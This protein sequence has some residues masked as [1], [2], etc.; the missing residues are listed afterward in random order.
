[1]TEKLS[2]NYWNNRYVDNATGW[3]I[4]FISTPLKEYI[5]QL[6]DKNIS[7][8][9]PGCGN[10]H[11][12]KYLLTKGFT[13]ITLI[14]ISELLTN[15]L[16]ENF[17]AHL[18]KEITIL[19]QDFFCLRNI[20]FDLIIEQTFFCAINPSLR[21][22]CVK[23]YSSLLKSKGKV[24][25]LLFNKQFENNPP[26]GGSEEEYRNYFKAN[27]HIKKMELCYNSIEPRKNSELFFIAEK[28]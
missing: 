12:A 14:D 22:T 17:S 24:V 2:E 23:Q 4:G 20:Q 25:G 27:F 28:K 7:I 5:D 1:M 15:N 8:L 3:D 9:I 21:Q 16:K 19:H 10:A 26:F 13:N 11:E 18:N 6:E